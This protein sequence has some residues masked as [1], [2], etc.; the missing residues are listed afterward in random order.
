RGGG[1]PRTVVVEDDL[2]DRAAAGVACDGAAAADAGDR[3]VPG[4][5]A[6]LCDR[7]RGLLPERDEHRRSGWHDGRDG[8]VRGPCVFRDLRG[9][10]KPRQGSS[11]K[12]RKMIS[13]KNVSKWYGSFQVLTDCSTAVKKGEVVVVC[14]PSGS[15]KSTLIKTV[16]G[17]EP[18]QK[19]EI[20]INGQL[21]GDPKTNLSKL[22]AKVGM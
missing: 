6:G 13:I 2:P 14:G 12:G 7:R 8:P 21:V 16:N 20:E 19:G 10:V 4:H 3:I 22:R 17:L 18:F 11:E 5:V 9:G 1:R 15:G